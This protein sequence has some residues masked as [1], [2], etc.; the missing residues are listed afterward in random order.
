MAKLRALHPA[1]LTAV[2]CL[3]LVPFPANADNKV[4]GE[5]SFRPADKTAQMSGVWVDNQYVGYVAELKGNRKLLLL[6]GQHEISIRQSGYI[7]FNERVN[8]QPGR[9]IIMRVMMAKSPRAQLPDLTAEIKFKVNPERAAVNLD[10][11]FAGT[12]GEFSGIGRAM[13]VKPG[14]HHLRIDMPG[15]RQFNTDVNLL[16]HQTITIRTKLIPQP[17]VQADPTL[18]IE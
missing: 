16:P 11:A 18:G 14:K 6:S 2:I 5:I 7:D 17:N 3:S 12:V 13:L 10:D 4:L 8:V 15:Y 1:V 9:K